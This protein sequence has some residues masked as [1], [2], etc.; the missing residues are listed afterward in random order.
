MS[1]ATVENVRSL[2][3][4]G[5]AV[6]AVVTAGCTS[7]AQHSNGGQ[8]PPSP[9][10]VLEVQ[11]SDVPIYSEFAAQTFARNG[12]EV[13]ARV[14][15]YIE[16]WLFRPGQ[17][18]RAGQML[19]VLDLRPY[20]AAVQQAA[21]SV[22]E[23]E[24]DALFARQQVALLQAEANLAVS[25]ANLVKARQ[26]QER[27]KPLVEQDAAPRQDLDTAVAAFRA[28]EANVRA[29]KANVEQ[30]RLA[31]QTQIQSSE[32]RLQSQK[33]A[34]RN[35]QLNLEY[36]TIKAPISGVIGD[37][38]VPVGGMVNANSAQPLTTVV[39]LDTM[40]V[41]LQMSERE[42]LAYGRRRAAT[43]RDVP[44]ELLLSDQSA[45]PHPGRIDSVL[46]QVDP[47]TGTLEV[48]ARFPNPEQKLLPGQF[49]RVRFQ[50]E[51]RNGV[52]VVPQRAVQQMQNMQ[53]VYTVA[54]DNKVQAHAVKTGE[55]VGDGWIVE[56]GLKPGDKVIVEGLM[57]IRPGVPV[58]PT[59]YR[60]ANGK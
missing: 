40:W 48:Q 18:V 29:N 58:R 47:R 35:A 44:L 30:T 45:F 14:D 38:Q 57:R 7:K 54:A 46:N 15:G 60:P 1:F 24:A 53:T 4:S 19:Y 56:Q 34:L 59:P 33:G 13:R 17:K 37:T 23:T 39:P 28:A 27:L 8:P 50:T 2:V 12:V 6:L 3:L 22:K 43:G 5:A 41:R 21:G 32:G 26:D 49:G 51:Q 42:Y 52:L 36:G 55:R 20:Q 10:E 9:V 16:K 31:A 25:E 11:A